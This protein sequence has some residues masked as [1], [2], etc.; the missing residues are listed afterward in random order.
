[1]TRAMSRRRFCLV[2]GA[3]LVAGACGGGAGGGGRDLSTAA[4]LAV[5]PDLVDPT[6]AD[7]NGV[8]H[9]GPAAKL[10]VDS[11]IYFNCAHVLVC[12]DAAGLYAMTS[13]CTHE[14]CDVEFVAPSREFECP[15]HLSIYDF[16]GAV[17]QSPAVL[18]LVHYAVSLDASGNVLVDVGQKVDAATRVADHD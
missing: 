10:A 4:D 12:R 9:A 5:G 15:C 13:V 14:Q 1:M 3:G 7:A 11:A 18:P 6:C 17:V 8:L 2:T 16:N